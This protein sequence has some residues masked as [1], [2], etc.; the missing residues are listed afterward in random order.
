MRRTAATHLFREIRAP[1]FVEPFTAEKRAHRGPRPVDAFTLPC[2]DDVFD[3]KRMTDEYHLVELIL[4]GLYTPEKTPFIVTQGGTRRAAPPEERRD[5]RQ[6]RG[7]AGHIDAHR[8][9]D[10]D[11]ASYLVDGEKISEEEVVHAGG[12]LLLQS[13]AWPDGRRG[14][15]TG[16]GR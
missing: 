3:E 7:D 9:A 6:C 4:H 14:A 15:R 16:T 1:V 13:T 10:D 5:R 12:F 11:E 8:K 2:F